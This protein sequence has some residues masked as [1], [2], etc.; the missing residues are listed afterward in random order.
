MGKST[1][2]VTCKSDL[3][4]N[5]RRKERED[6][7]RLFVAVLEQVSCSRKGAHRNGVIQTITY[8]PLSIISD[9]Q[10]RKKH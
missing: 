2:T 4:A 5:K 10:K 6:H 9:G 3:I 7:G 8:P 1:F